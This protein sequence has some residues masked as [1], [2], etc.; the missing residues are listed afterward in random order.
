MTDGAD[1]KIPAVFKFIIKFITPL[2]LGWVF[3]ASLP[4]IWKQIKNEAIDKQIL[5]A[6]DPKIIEQL[7]I[8]ML[9]VNISR[10]GLV[11]VWLGIAYLVFVAY[12]K[13]VKEGRFSS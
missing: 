8:Q 4:G 11:L 1:I 9:Y 7:Q 13:R 2:L 10:I 5:A 3:I 12:K 6:T